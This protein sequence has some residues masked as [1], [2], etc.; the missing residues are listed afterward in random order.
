MR[1]TTGLPEQPHLYQL[2]PPPL[3]G[4]LSASWRSPA[5]L[6]GTN[7]APLGPARLRSAPLSPARPRSPPLGSTR[8]RSA[9]PDRL[10]PLARLNSAHL[11]GPAALLLSNRRTNWICT[12]GLYGRGWVRLG[13]LRPP[14][15]CVP[16]SRLH[17]Q[18]RPLLQS[19]EK[20]PG[21]FPPVTD[22]APLGEPVAHDP[23]GSSGFPSSLRP[24]GLRGGPGFWTIA[25]ST[26]KVTG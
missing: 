4:T 25:D 17:P 18:P 22:P 26:H 21:T 1:R 13:P 2:P 12:L 9:L 11:L 7:S 15:G 19:P 16:H 8:P 23:Q 10:R 20:P 24:R 5:L 6:R 3:G 14:S